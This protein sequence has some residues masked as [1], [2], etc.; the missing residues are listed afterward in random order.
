M[1][2]HDSRPTFSIIIPVYNGENVLLE[3]LNSVRKFMNLSTTEVIVI[4]DGS[5][6]ATESIVSHKFPDFHLINKVNEGEAAAVNTGLEIATGK[7]G[8]VISADDPLLGPEIFV[9]AESIFESNPE[10]SVV[11]FDWWVI[12]EFS[13]KMYLVKKPDYSI[14]ELLGKFNCLPGPGSFFRIDFAKSIGGRDV[15]FKYVSDYDFWLRMSKLGPFKHVSEP[16]AQWREHGDSTSVKSKGIA[17]AKERILVIEKH[18][19]SHTYT[20]RIKK[21][22]LSAAYYNAAILSYFTD[23]VPGKKYI[24]TALKINRMFI[25]GSKF[26]IVLYIILLPY[27]KS[28]LRIASKLRLIKKIHR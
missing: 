16:L 15:S 3:T 19:A 26:H 25:P 24:W 23:D 17:M 2:N 10:L 18:L 13:E 11:Y 20:E 28:I 21:N 9:R 7:Y 4:N 12:N 22:A 1:N 5:I 27:S 14:E 6:D 8:L